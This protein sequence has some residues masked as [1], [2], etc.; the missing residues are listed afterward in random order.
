MDVDILDDDEF[1]PFIVKIRIANAD[2]L[3]AM[4]QAAGR[5]CNGHGLELYPML[6][7]KCRELGVEE[8]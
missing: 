1:K 5:L 8:I 4:T 3:R 6:Q 7:E 2:E